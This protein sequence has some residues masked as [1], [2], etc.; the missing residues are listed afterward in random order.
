MFSLD[1]HSSLLARRL[2]AARASPPRLADTAAAILDYPLAVKSSN[3]DFPNI[4]HNRRVVCGGEENK[5]RQ[6]GHAINAL[7]ER[8]FQKFFSC[9]IFKE[10]LVL[11]PNH[12]S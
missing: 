10:N 11:P 1:W 6:P 7:D 9:F 3:I 4:E 5:F 8:N 12:Q 2:T